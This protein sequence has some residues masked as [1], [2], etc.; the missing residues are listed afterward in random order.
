MPKAEGCRRRVCCDG[1]LRGLFFSP[2]SISVNSLHF[3]LRFV[4]C[5]CK[6]AFWVW[7][8]FKVVAPPQSLLMTPP[9]LS[10]DSALALL[11]RR[12]HW[13]LFFQSVI[14]PFFTS[15]F[16]RTAAPLSG[17]VFAVPTSPLRLTLRAVVVTP[18]SLE[19]TTAP[20][21]VPVTYESTVEWHWRW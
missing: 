5:F 15:L 1:D 13:V 17:A 18:L 7:L 21:I 20:K 2:G 16:V 19:S 9:S 8:L 11:T 10:P 14:G 6:A 4:K 12:L 3:G